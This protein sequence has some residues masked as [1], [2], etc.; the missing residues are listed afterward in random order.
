MYV[1]DVPTAKRMC[2]HIL[3]GLTL[4]ILTASCLEFSLWSGGHFGPNLHNSQCMEG[5]ESKHISAICDLR[6]N[7]CISTW[8]LHPHSRVKK[9][10]AY[11]TTASTTC[12]LMHLLSS[13]NP[14]YW[15][16]HMNY[17]WAPEKWILHLMNLVCGQLLY[18]TIPST[19]YSYCLIFMAAS[20]KWRWD[21]YSN[22]RYI[23]N[24][25]QHSN[26]LLPIQRILY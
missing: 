2:W 20:S 17:G 13:W 21:K 24:V 9:H 10:S 7:A 8:Y 26:I 19:T 16:K 14:K 25:S 23:R 18:F 5:L 15:Q 11:H 1:S 22:I 6:M 3:K 4:S 12:W